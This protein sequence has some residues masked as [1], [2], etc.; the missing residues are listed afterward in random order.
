MFYPIIEYFFKNKGTTVYEY[1]GI[2][3]S[4]WCQ[5]KKGTKS[6]LNINHLL[7]IASAVDMLLDITEDIEVI[8]KKVAVKMV[9]N[10]YE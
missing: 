10:Y 4:Y 5:I 2:N 3:R 8:K 7:K 6:Q 9:E 1:I